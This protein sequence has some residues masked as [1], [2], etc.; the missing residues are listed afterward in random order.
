M[1]KTLKRFSLILLVM[2]ILFQTNLAQMESIHGSI[3]PKT[4]PLFSG[5][6]FEPFESISR[7]VIGL[8]NREI[9]HQVPGDGEIYL[10]EDSA[11][12]GDNITI[13]LYR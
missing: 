9:H 5:L 13:S 3:V 11:L 7:A 6:P 12:C 4:I 2:M 8:A 1:T 10:Q